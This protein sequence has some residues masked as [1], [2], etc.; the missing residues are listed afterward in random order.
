MFNF[1]KSTIS[2]NCFAVPSSNPE[3]VGHG[4][5]NGTDQS[6][7]GSAAMRSATRNQNVDL[8]VL[9]KAQVY[10]ILR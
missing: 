1:K 10:I 5:H 3:I 4:T 6:Q 2:S 7:R 9:M 8:M